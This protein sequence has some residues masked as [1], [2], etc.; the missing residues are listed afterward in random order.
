MADKPKG[1]SKAD[2]LVSLESCLKREQFDSMKAEVE[3]LLHGLQVQE[4][5]LEA[6]NRELRE[7]QHALEQSRDRYAE[8]YDC[9][10]IGYLSLDA[11]GIIQ[12]LNTMGTILLGYERARLLGYPLIHYIVPQDRE[13]FLGH[14]RKCR[15]RGQALTELALLTKEGG[16]LPAQLYSRALGTK[17]D[18]PRGVQYLT[19]V[20]DV[21]EQ[22]QAEELRLAHAE[23]E[24][25]AAQLQQADRRKNEFL[26][27]LSHELR[28]PLAPIKNAVQFLK[29]VKLADP[30]LKLAQEIIERQTTHLVR[31]VDDLLDVSRL[32]QGRLAL[33]KAPLDLA[34]VLA[35]ALEASQPLIQSRHH[36][37]SVS[38][39][40]PP[41]RVEGDSLRLVQV[42]SNLLDNAAQY[43]PPGGRIWLSALRKGN[44]ALISV[45]DTGLGLSP[46]LLFQLFELFAQ[47]ERPR[48]RSQGRLGIGLALVK[49]LVELH[50]GRVEA[51][52]E[53]IGKGSEFLVWLPVLT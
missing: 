52:S 34:A 26:A 36:E 11:K 42:V 13:K 9:A 43:T 44:K 48:D 18:Q 8:L 25:L 31:L 51:R 19:A 1:L 27:I 32:A 30:R 17:K 40:D 53:G 50:G 5:E 7:T 45:R 23:Q 2:L 15:E 33:Q 24:R 22:K 38:L 14:M 29:Q 49:K 16:R 47:A 3:R 6:Q 39:P 35:Q 12:E 10:P 37:L 46:P 21:S 41:L 4:L 28:N 20:V